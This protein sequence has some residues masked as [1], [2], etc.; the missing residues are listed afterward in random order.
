MKNKIKKI[1]KKIKRDGRHRTA[2]R[3]ARRG[4]P[5]NSAQ[6]DNRIKLISCPNAAFLWKT[7]CCQPQ[8]SDAKSSLPIPP[9]QSPTLPCGTANWCSVSGNFFFGAVAYRMIAAMLTAKEWPQIAEGAD[10]GRFDSDVCVPCGILCR[11]SHRSG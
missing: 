8:G 11:R 3:R 4:F 2:F 5:V 10:L 1:L 9:Q 7:A 6:L